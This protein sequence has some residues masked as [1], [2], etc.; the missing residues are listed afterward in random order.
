LAD[1]IKSLRA[2]PVF[3]RKPDS[4]TLDQYVRTR[5]ARTAFYLLKAATISSKSL[6]LIANAL[7]VID[8][9]P[10]ENPSQDNIIRA[11]EKAYEKCGAKRAPTFP[12]LRKTFL[13]IF[14]ERCWRGSHRDPSERGSDYAVRKTLK[15]LGLPLTRASPGRRPDH[16]H[17]LATEH[18]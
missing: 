17:E 9:D 5:R 14:G 4:R 7:D 13:A 18:G 1:M 12:E 10:G 2:V 6:R 15:S 16:P 3:P 8:A 11:Y